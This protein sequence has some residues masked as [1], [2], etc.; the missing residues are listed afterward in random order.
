MPPRLDLSVSVERM[1]RAPPGW[2][3]VRHDAA[4]VLADDLL[5][6]TRATEGSYYPDHVIF[7]GPAAGS[8][9]RSDDTPGL[10]KILAGG[11]KLV[12]IPGNG[13][14]LPAEAIAA[15]DELA[16]CLALVLA[17]IPAGARLRPIGAQA[18]AMLL[19]WDAEKYRQALAKARS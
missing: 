2:R 11:Q 1:L 12:L 16:L 4:H 15:A 8:V 19:N 17:R 7:L 13:A 18:E 3:P 14:F 10:A 9:A 5:S 6:L